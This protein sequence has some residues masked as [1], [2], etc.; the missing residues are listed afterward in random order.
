MTERRSEGFETYLADFEKF[1]QLDLNILAT[2]NQN[3]GRLSGICLQNS[4]RK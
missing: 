4:L 1:K 2:S 3:I